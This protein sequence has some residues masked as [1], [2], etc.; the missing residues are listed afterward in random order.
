LWTRP[1]HKLCISPPPPPSSPKNGGKREQTGGLKRVSRGAGVGHPP[2]GL[3]KQILEYCA[4]KKTPRGDSFSKT[5]RGEK[6]N[7]KINP[8]KQN[9]V[10]LLEFV[11][12]DP[13]KKKTYP[14]PPPPFPLWPLT[15]GFFFLAK[16]PRTRRGFFSPPGQKKTFLWGKW[17]LSVFS[18]S[19]HPSGHTPPGAPEKDVPFPFGEPFG[20]GGGKEA[21]RGSKH[22]PKNYGGVL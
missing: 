17:A 21:P 14:Q 4:K 7:S 8:T 16:C 22:P 11:F 19:S 13:F 6:P 12:S 15:T 9:L 10:H 1:G 3:K 5:G 18:F 20:G 2:T